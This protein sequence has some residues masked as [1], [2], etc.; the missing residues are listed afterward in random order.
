MLGAYLTWICE[1]WWRGP[2][3]IA[4]CGALIVV[5]AL[6]VLLQSTLYSPLEERD[7]SR[8][9]ILLASLGAYIVL[10]N[11]V[12]LVC[13]DDLQMFLVSGH[14]WILFGA[15]ISS[16]RLL[17]CI[18]NLFSY[19]ALILLLRRSIVG[20]V[21]R[22]VADDRELAGSLGISAK[23]VAFLVV[24]IS[25][26]L[27]SL[28]GVLIGYDQ[29]LQPTMGFEPLL[30][31]VAAAIIGGVGSVTGALGGAFLMSFIEVFG[32]WP[33]P[34]YW[35]RGLVFTA[36]CAIVAV[37]VLRGASRESGMGK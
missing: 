15:H 26:G 4:I 27:A 33:L 29:G 35:Q 32:V 16:I 12:S 36:V 3:F 5:S 14:T 2:A 34:T 21:I 30:M 11:L 9:G 19:A 10:Q 1:A 31:G 24:T 25:S 7:S 18:V 8:L 13:G 23:G 28:I 17:I 20:S 22:A 6:G 37:N